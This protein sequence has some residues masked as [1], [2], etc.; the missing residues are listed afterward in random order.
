MIWWILALAVVAV[1]SYLADVGIL[2]FLQQVKLP[3][4]KV[5]TLSILILLCTL[6]I[7]FRM[8]RR[9]KRGLRESLAKKVQ[10][11]ETEVSTLKQK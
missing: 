9:T 11:L 7:L 4:L 6:G 2:P 5:S 8:L 10:E 1:L 3:V